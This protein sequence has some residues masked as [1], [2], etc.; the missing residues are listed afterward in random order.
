MLIYELYFGKNIPISQLCQSII[1]AHQQFQLWQSC[2]PAIHLGVESGRQR[3]K[4]RFVAFDIFRDGTLT[5][6][7][8]SAEGPSPLDEL[9]D[10]E[11]FSTTAMIPYGP[12]GT[13]S[14]PFHNWLRCL[15]NDLSIRSR[16]GL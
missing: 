4:A 1:G 6:L 5:E 12:S 16:G 7:P 9:N 11:A 8:V 13:G 2:Q 10:L 3:T 14:D 15:P